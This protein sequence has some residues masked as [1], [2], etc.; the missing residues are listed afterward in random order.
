MRIKCASTLQIIE[1]QLARLGEITRKSL[2][3]YCAEAE[4]KE[5]DLVA[6]AEAAIRLHLQGLP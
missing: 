6:I 5:F 1:A 2:A 3:F 4:P